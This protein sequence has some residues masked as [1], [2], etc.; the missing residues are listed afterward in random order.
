MLW[1]GSDWFGEHVNHLL[2]SFDLGGSVAAVQ[3]AANW[4]AEMAA[5]AGSGL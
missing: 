4:L 3:L 1:N 5:F 2:N